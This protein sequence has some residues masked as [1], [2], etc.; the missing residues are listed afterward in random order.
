MAIF[1]TTLTGTFVGMTVENVLHFDNHGSGITPLTICQIVRDQW[2]DQWKFFS[3]TLVK[4]LQIST[5]QIDPVLGL[6]TN[7]AVNIDGSGNAAANVDLP[8]VAWKVR[9]QT[10][11]PGRHGRGRLFPPVASLAGGNLGVVN[12]AT[13]DT[14]N[15]R[16]VTLLNRFKD[17]DPPFG[18]TFGI[19]PRD[20]PSAFKPALNMFVA[21]TY[22][23]VRRRQI[24]VG[25]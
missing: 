24:G 10:N 25:I 4:W 13:L 7:L 8:F 18:I 12:Q 11:T 22:G 1:R 17:D 16:L 9:I 15:A 6:T 5:T 3:V 21:S 19:L 14:L 20:T 2:L 23:I